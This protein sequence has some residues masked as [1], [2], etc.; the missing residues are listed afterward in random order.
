MGDRAL[1]RPLAA[2]PGAANAARDALSCALG[3][4]VLRSQA[5]P[6]RRAVVGYVRASAAPHR[7]IAGGPPRGVGRRAH[8]RQ[9]AAEARWQC[10]SFLSLSL[11]KRCPRVTTRIHTPLTHPFN[12]HHPKQTTASASAATYPSFSAA[13][14]ANA[15]QFSMISGY[16]SKAGMA[17]SFANPNLINTVFVPTNAAFT[18]VAKSTGVNINSFPAATIKQVIYYHVTKGAYTT[19]QMTN[20][21]TLPTLLNG[22]SLKV[23]KAG[24]NVVVNGVGSSAAVIPALAN[25]VC[26]KGIAQGVNNVLLPIKLSGR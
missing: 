6:P 19:A 11:F 3:S 22:Q 18:A 16:L 4:L 5:S 12:H 26:G 24:S 9:R 10:R 14:S 17:A 15:G 25:I 23:A 20:G 7:T 2:R 8:K 13:L 21:M 1:A